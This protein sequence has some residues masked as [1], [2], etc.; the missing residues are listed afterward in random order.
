MIEALIIDYVKADPHTTQ[1]AIIEA[2]G[3]S[4][5]SI[6]EGFA[7]LQ[8]RGVLVMEGSKQKPTWVLREKS[9]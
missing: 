9:H 4:K 3:K 1:K 6:Q 7:S 8:A 5:R 2:S